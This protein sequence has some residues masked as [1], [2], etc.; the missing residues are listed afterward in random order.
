MITREQ[1][2]CKHPNPCKDQGIDQRPLEQEPEFNRFVEA[3]L[4]RRGFLMATG[5]VGSV[6]FF[7]ATPL[8]QAVASAVAS[9]SALMGFEGIAIS[10][11]DSVEV[12]AGYRA[13]VLISWGDAVV[14]GAPAFEQGNDAQAQALQFGDNNDGMT[15]FSLSDDRAVLAV[16]NEYTNN[17]YLYPHQGQSIS[18]DDAFKAQA[19]HG[20]SI[21]ELSKQDG[22]WRVNP[23]GRLNRR[24][25][26][27][28]EMDITG[29]AAGH[30]LLKTNADKSGRK[31]LGTFNN[32]ANGETPWGTYLTCEE[33]FNGYFAN[34]S[35]AKLADT[36]ARYG[37]NEQDRGYE[38]YKHD[39]RFDMGIEPNEAH[40]HGWVVEIDPM[41][42]NSTPKKRTA[43]GRFKHENAALM[44]D[45]SGH[46]VVYLGDDERGEHL[47]K[48]VS[49]NK[50]RPGAE[51]NLDLL[52]EGTLYVAKFTGSEGE[53]K[54]QGQWIEL[55][56]GKN[57]LTPENG[58][59]DA[60]SVMIFARQAATQ[61]GATTMDR[62]EWVAVHPQHD[63]V[64]VTLTNNKYRGV[65]DNQP[66]NAANPREK[67]PY[68]HIVRWRPAGGDHTSESFAWDIYVLAG[69]PTVHESG[70][71]AGSDNITADNMFNSPDGIGFDRFGRL[72]IQTDGK[73]SNQ[74][75]YA[76]MGNNQMLCSDPQSGEIRR[77]LTGP[78][79]C[80]ITGLTFSPDNTAMFVGVQH[81]GEDLAPS[82]FPDGGQSIPRSSVLVITREDGGIIGA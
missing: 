41:N 26:A 3:A 35:K 40:R 54:G 13:D 37:L 74:G 70:L 27:N 34:P 8:S 45:K 9:P 68:G 52:D 28:T 62:P 67:N 44:V 43:L 50:Y 66:L 55:T 58:F 69:N 46:V 60:A 22:T 4:S 47:Y 14:K 21:V 11:K 78:I 31:V 16:N 1:S 2:R 56:W 48:F 75:D 17:E 5:A 20:V 82:H 23:N 76:G 81:P 59:A 80:E 36:Y 71:M 64:F 12:P 49:K 7:G 39:S 32:C 57:G 77:F 6:A 33:N 51:T 18:R 63:S 73:Y 30:D 42:P 15:F 38:W 79:A 25:T 65:R 19:A 10:T 24:I 61:V 29:P 53:L 72:W